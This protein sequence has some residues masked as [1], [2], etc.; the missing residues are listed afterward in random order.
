MDIFTNFVETI[1]F[2]S[3]EILQLLASCVLQG[4]FLPNSKAIYLFK[5]TESEELL[6]LGAQSLLRFTTTNGG[7]FTAQVWDLIT[8]K[9]DSIVSQITS[10]QQ[11][12]IKSLCASTAPAAN[13]GSASPLRSSSKLFGAPGSPL[14]QSTTNLPAPLAM[15]GQNTPSPAIG[16]RRA[17]VVSLRDGA[18][19]A[20]GFVQS[21]LRSRMHAHT[22]ALQLMVQIVDT[23]ATAHDTYPNMTARHLMELANA[24]EGGYRFCHYTVVE[25]LKKNS[26]A[27]SGMQ[28]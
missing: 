22:I 24:L 19:G 8:K 23:I 15:Q 2:L 28:F 12:I 4:L 20:Q 6:R 7:K 25:V 13:A 21:G 14:R 9:I 27:T 17:L 1:D 5:F 18:Q 26:A 16:A 10:E 11:D 3:S